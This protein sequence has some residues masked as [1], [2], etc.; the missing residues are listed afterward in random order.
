MLVEGISLVLLKFRLAEACN[1]VQLIQ[2]CSHI[3]AGSWGTHELHSNSPS[4]VSDKQ[5][6]LLLY[7]W[8]FSKEAVRLFLSSLVAMWGVP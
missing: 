1:V 3:L 7:Q 4:M 8:H 2:N 5:G 6:W